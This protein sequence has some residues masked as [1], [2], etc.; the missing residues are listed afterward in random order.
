[1]DHLESIAGA[2]LWNYKNSITNTEYGPKLAS[3]DAIILEAG[4]LFPRFSY[5]KIIWS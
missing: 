1:M 5:L 2:Y 4:A 3:N